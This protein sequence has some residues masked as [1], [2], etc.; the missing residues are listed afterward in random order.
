MILAGETR[1]IPG[2]RTD[3]IYV[4]MLNFIGFLMLPLYLLT[5]ENRLKARTNKAFL[6]RD[7]EKGKVLANEFK[8]KFNV[9]MLDKSPSEEGE[10]F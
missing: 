3:T 4:I 5:P 9:N 7:F 1:E 10:N 2:F 6:S 8:E